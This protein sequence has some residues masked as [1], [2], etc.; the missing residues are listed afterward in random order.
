MAQGGRN[1]NLAC[2]RRGAA[3]EFSARYD[4]AALFLAGCH[5]YNRRLLSPM[6]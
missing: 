1:L 4:A 6:S 3:P 2:A 5:P